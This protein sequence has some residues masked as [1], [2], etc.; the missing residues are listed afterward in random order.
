MA[1]EDPKSNPWIVL[2]REVKFDSPY[3]N[4]REDSVSFR[5]RPARPYTSIRAKVHGVCIASVDWDGCVTLVGQYRYV[6]DRFTWELPGGGVPVGVDPLE[7]AKAELSEEAGQRAEQWFNIV[8]GAAS[9]GTS[10]EFVYGYVAWDIEQAVSHPEPEEELTLRR[11]PFCQALDMALRGEIA[12]LIG[13]A[14]LL[15]I[16]TRLRRGDLPKSLVDLLH[17]VT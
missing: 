2:S 15:G 3:F 10:D 8:E 4:A 9:I 7:V 16:D 12:H 11:L 13:T 1:S 5:G 6:L 17:R 14:L